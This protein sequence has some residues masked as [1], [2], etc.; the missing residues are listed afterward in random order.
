MFEE[1][2]IEQKATY[3]IIFNFHIQSSL[4]L[5]S[6]QLVIK[7][8]IKASATLTYICMYIQYMCVC[9]FIYI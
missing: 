4:Y 5:S 2:F 6:V 3:L 1:M 7:I 9:M 8:R